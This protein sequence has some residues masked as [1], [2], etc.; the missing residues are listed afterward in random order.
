[1]NDDAFG[2]AGLLGR[3][4]PKMVFGGLV[5]LLMVILL[6]L[7]WFGQ[8][9]IKADLQAMMTEQRARLVVQT[10]AERDRFRAG[11][12]LCEGALKE[13]GLCGMV[14]PTSYSYGR[15]NALWVML[16]GVTILADAELN[17]DQRRELTRATAD[18]VRAVNAYGAL[19]SVL[20]G[21]QFPDKLMANDLYAAVVAQA[22]VC[23]TLANDVACVDGLPEAVR[24]SLRALA[25]FVAEVGPVASGYE[26]APR[27][28]GVKTVLASL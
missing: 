8:M 7:L 27:M 25:E 10:T 9:G 4:D 26:T 17:A 28:D 21:D 19:D 14:T 18:L 13:S 2:R 16:D 20:A 23:K 5:V 12:L 15:H 11:D 3:S 1:M 6:M 22:M 24:G